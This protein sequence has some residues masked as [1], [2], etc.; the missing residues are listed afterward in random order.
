MPASLAPEPPPCI[1]RSASR[2]P[3]LGAHSA[4]EYVVGTETTGRSVAADTALARSMAL[5]PPT[6]SSPSAFPAMRAMSSIRSLGTS[7]QRPTAGRSSSDQRS[8]AIR[9]GR[10][11]STSRSTPG[12]SRRPQR[13]ITPPPLPQPAPLRPCSWGLAA[14]PRNRRPRRQNRYGLQAASQAMPWR[15]GL[16]HGIAS[17]ASRSELR[18][19]EGNERF[20]DT[21]RRASGGADER[22]LTRGVEALYASRRERA[23]R[24]LGVDA[25]PRDEGDAEACGDGALHG[26]LQPQLEPDVEVAQPE[27]AVAELVLDHLPHAR[28]FLHQDQRLAAEVLERHLL[29][30][31]PMAGRNRE[32]HLVAEERLED[33]TAVTR[34]GAHDP[35]LELALRHLLDDA[36]R[37]RDRQGDAQLGVF[38]LELAEQHRNDRATRSG[39]G[40]ER[41]LAAQHTIVAGELVEEVPLEHEHPLRG[42]VEPLPGFGRLDPAPR[43][44]EQ[45]GSEPLLQRP[46]L[47]ADRRLGHPE[48]LGRLGEALPVNHLAEGGELSRVHK[49]SLWRRAQNRA[50]GS[51]ERRKDFLA[52]A[53]QL[54]RP[55][56]R[57]RRQFR[58]RPWAALRDLLERRVVEDD[59]CRDLVGLRPLEAPLLQRPERRGQLSFG[60]PVRCLA[61]GLD[62]E[63]GEEAARPPRP[64][65]RQV[66]SGSGDADVEQ[67]ALLRN[68]LVVAERLLARELALLDPRQ[69][70][71]IPLE[72]FGAVQRQQVDTALGAVVEPLAQPRD[73]SADVARAVVELLREEDQARQVAL[74][75][76]L[77]LSETIGR[78]RLPAML[79]RQTPDLVRNRARR[80]ACQPLQK[81]P[82]GV[83]RQ[84]CGALERDLRIAEG[85]FE[86]DRPGIQTD[87]DRHLL[88]RRAGGVKLADSLDDELPFRL[89]IGKAAQLRLGASAVRLAQ[90]LLGPAEPRH[91]TVGKPEHLRRGT[92]VRLQPHDGRSRKAFRQ[93]EQVL[94]R[95]AGERI[96]RL[97]VGADRAELVAFAKPQLEQRLLQQ[98]DVLVLVDREGA[99]A[100]LH[101]CKRVGLVL[102]QLDREPQ[103]VL[104]VER[105]GR[106]LA[107]LVLAEHARHQVVRNR[108]LVAVQAAAVGLGGQPPVLR[109]LD[110][111]REVDGGPEL[112]RH[113][114]H[115]AD[116]PQHQRLG[117]QDLSGQLSPEPAQLGEGR[118][119][120]GSRTNAAGAELFQPAPHLARRLVGEC[121]REDLLGREGAGRDLVRDPARDR[122]RLPRA[123]AGEDAD[124]PA[125]RLDR[126]PLLRVQPV[127]DP[128]LVHRA[129]LAP[130]RDG[131]RQRS[132][133]KLR[134]RTC[135]TR[136]GGRSHSRARTNGGA[137][138]TSRASTF[139]CRPGPASAPGSG[140]RR[141]RLRHRAP[142]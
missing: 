34:R 22:D 13:T 16:F 139:P 6:A 41:Q 93:R 97:V 55:D 48:P 44:V 133:P 60:P 66:L 102:E 26:L 25:R 106:L 24:E 49:N 14:A 87:Q 107:T 57:N 11:I 115:V 4:P 23:G 79:V 39:R 89:A 90:L 53:L 88:E 85:F 142:G 98:V 118:R 9:N 27:W 111:G 121:D 123:R 113:R 72:T 105:T 68:R 28:T 8:L 128:C 75:C 124:R 100:V 103:Q 76:Q 108:R 95:G 52:V 21:G 96:N 80:R 46:N 110:F 64:R 122:R 29:A 19:G 45:L 3:K 104:E 1:R 112:V 99:V 71:G 129:T 83:S 73:P 120:E 32:D 40:A 51:R 54:R 43:P 86:V 62:A 47:E 58:E 74:S 5:P 119:M 33:D 10:S 50:L 42:A 132:V 35:Q 18:A 114:Q 7:L 31:E 109:P 63:L 127:E 30:G 117:G 67:P 140:R 91:E 130:G 138:P 12:S 2:I 92:V 101:L 69:E 126:A 17:D 137:A 116:L 36:I 131:V 15:R 84:Q 141:L 65:Q 82:G 135:R 94:R 70:D 38:A 134:R 77:A 20:C 136:P 125:N 78:R 61:P 56:A 37:V 81:L 59:V